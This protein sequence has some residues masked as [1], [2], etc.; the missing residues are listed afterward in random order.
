MPSKKEKSVRTVDEDS[1][2]ESIDFDKKKIDELFK[3]YDGGDG[4][5]REKF[6]RFFEDGENNDCLICKLKL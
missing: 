5:D 3:N 2:E 6:L 4:R 1:E